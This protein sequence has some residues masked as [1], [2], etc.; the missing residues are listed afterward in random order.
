ME[1]ACD[2]S[3]V[4]RDFCLVSEAIFLLEEAEWKKGP[5]EDSE[6]IFQHF[7]RT[8]PCQQG[9]ICC[10]LRLGLVTV[11]EYTNTCRVRHT[12]WTEGSSS[13]RTSCP[14]LVQLK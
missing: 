11:C 4:Y 6:D 1:K 13:S 2:L 7:G 10:C 5:A 9:Q 14:P 12:T 8:A 3:Y